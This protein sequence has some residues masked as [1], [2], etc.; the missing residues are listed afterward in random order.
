M[1]PI[2]VIGRSFGAGGRALGREIARLMDIPYYDNELLSTAARKLGFDSEIFAKADEKRPSF[3]R[4]F[5]TRSYGIQETFTPD[6]LSAESLYEAQSRVIKEVAKSG[7]C[8]IVGR[9]AD[10]ILRDHPALTSVFLHAP[11]T[12]RAQKILERGDAGDLKSALEL[13]RKCD[14]ER[15]AYYNYFTGRKWGYA[16]NYHYTFDSSKITPQRIAGVIR[17]LIMNTD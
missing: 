16:E 5:V 7:G 13:A 14:R 6:T 1:K 17:D 12:F 4:R 10:Y 11:R 8:V 9:T 15:E 2:I 3:F